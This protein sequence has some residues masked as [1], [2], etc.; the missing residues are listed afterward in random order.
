M[1]EST[2][3]IRPKV[4]KTTA[5]VAVGS[6]STDVA[7]EETRQRMESWMGLGSDDEVK[8]PPAAMS[9][10][11]QSKPMTAA[12]TPKATE[13]EQL[14]VVKESAPPK[15]TAAA[16]ASILKTPKYSNKPTPVMATVSANEPEVR[17]HV[18]SKSN[19]KDFICK[20]VVVER[21]P[22]KPM[23]KRSF[24]KK[25]RQPN[26]HSAVEGYVPN[27]AVAEAS[28]KSPETTTTV[29]FDDT[30]KK[31]K[32]EGEEDSPLILSSVEE[33][34]QAAGHKLPDDPTK[35]TPDTQLVEADIAFSVMTQNQ[36]DGK[37]GELK[38]EQE[39][40]LQA[41]LK[42][43]MGKANAFQDQDGASN[44]DKDD[45][46]DEDDED[47]FMEMLMEQDVDDD[48]FDYNYGDDGEI[49]ELEIRAFR[50]FW[51]ALSDWITPEAVDWMARLERPGG[52][53][54][55]QNNN[56]WTPQVDRSD[57]GASRCA[58][59]M[60]MIK[61]YLPRS[62]D[63]LQHPKDIRRTA[64]KRLGD[65]LRTFTYAH[66]APKLQTKLWKAMT[67]IFLDMVLIETRQ[68]DKLPPSVQAVGMTLDEY[69]YLTQSAVPTFGKGMY[70]KQQQRGETNQQ[71]T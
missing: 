62:L 27:V 1:S 47:D 59:L 17:Q 39:D 67:C 57:V 26:Q 15:P 44:G 65:F 4:R 45:D 20:N 13:P 37:L 30:A 25:T 70:V 35:I 58:G 22:T 5:N 6:T 52:G 3:Q 9:V 7:V 36:Y 32:E 2:K 34:F 53:E 68:P 71:N 49:A 24:R 56:E 43:F 61:L 19:T 63:E 42:M 12:S 23:L 10:E 40:E 8:E 31:Q 14:G 16:A 28:S 11:R 55:L 69:R 29:H 38:R 21:D 50:N 64:E 48:A 54:K 46:E 66:E 51:D 41:Q 60:A 18:A 33:M